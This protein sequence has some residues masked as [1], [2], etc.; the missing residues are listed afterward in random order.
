MPSLA[1]LGLHISPSSSPDYYP[2][3]T[4]STSCLVT[5]SWLY[6]LEAK[7][8]SELGSWN[9]CADGGPFDEQDG[10]T[11]DAV[12]KSAGVAL[13]SERNPTLAVGSNA[14]PAQLESKFGLAKGISDVVPLTRVTVNGVGVGHSAHISKQGY[15]AYTPV[16]AD[17]EMPLFMLWLDDEQLAHIHVTEPNYVPITLTSDEFPAVLETGQAVDSYQLYRSKWGTLRAANGGAQPATTQEKIIQLLAAFPALTALTPELG[18]G[19]IAATRVMAANE[20]LRN[21]MRKAFIDIGLT[22][23]DGLR[24]ERSARQQAVTQKQV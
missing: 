22:M 1:T 18:D 4:A 13:M 17:V 10:Q 23:P 16:K 7:N 15:V 11:L 12:L 8:D 5:R 6:P 20:E 2:G 19:H 3:L 24:K 9:V 21:R 14:A